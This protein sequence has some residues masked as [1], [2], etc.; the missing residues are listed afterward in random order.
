MRDR[1]RRRRCKLECP[2][3]KKGSCCPI[4][5][6]GQGR[7]HRR[8]H[9]IVY[10]LLWMMTHGKNRKSSYML[11]VL[12]SLQSTKETSLSSLSTF[13]T[14]SRFSVTKSVRGTCSHSV[15][16]L[17]LVRASCHSRLGSLEDDVA[18]ASL[19][20]SPTNAQVPARRAVL[21]TTHTGKPPLPLQLMLPDPFTLWQTRCNPF[22][23][24][25]GQ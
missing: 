1:G 11:L 22:F 24:G 14:S 5:G 12:V 18:K 19:S 25:G 8:C 6:F 4:Q 3:D 20:L 13:S 17:L 9:V 21:P 7:E 23:R 2:L 16:T 10:V 15:I